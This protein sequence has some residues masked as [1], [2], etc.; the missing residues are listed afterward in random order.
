LPWTPRV[1]D[2]LTVPYNFAALKALAEGKTLIPD[3]KQGT[4][5]EGVVVRP[6][7]ERWNSEIGRV[8]LKIV[9]SIF[10]GQ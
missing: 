9:S 1:T 10:L 4:I 2:I 6:A 5:R 8:Q 3:A 7:A